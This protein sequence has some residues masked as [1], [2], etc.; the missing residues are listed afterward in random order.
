[1]FR[2]ARSKCDIAAMES[3]GTSSKRLRVFRK[4]GEPR[5]V[6]G[7]FYAP[8]RCAFASTSKEIP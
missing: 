2:S 5:V 3:T 8:W 4:F 6:G 7:G 1:M